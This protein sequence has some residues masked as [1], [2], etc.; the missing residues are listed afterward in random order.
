MTWLVLSAIIIAFVLAVFFVRPA[1][2]AVPDGPIPLDK[3]AWLEA[4][5]R[6]YQKWVPADLYAHAMWATRTCREQAAEI[7]RLKG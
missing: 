4:K 3:L 6:S 7:E 2:A 5:I 1:A